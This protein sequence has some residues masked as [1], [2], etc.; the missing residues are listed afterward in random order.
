MHSGHPNGRLPPRRLPHLGLRTRRSAVARAPTPSGSL[1]AAGRL[2]PSPI[3]GPPNTGNRRSGQPPP[4]RGGSHARQRPRAP[5][6]CP[7]HYLLRGYALPPQRWHKVPISTQHV[8][9]HPPS[10]AR[11]RTQKPWCA[12]SS[13]STTCTHS[14]TDLPRAYG[15]HPALRHWRRR[16]QLIGRHGR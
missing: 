13:S 4:G 16:R 14:S 8:G 12:H 9:G 5:A 6:L 15:G 7:S 11:S 10:R 2:S 1:P 3:A